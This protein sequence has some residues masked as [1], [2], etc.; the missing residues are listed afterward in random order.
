VIKYLT[1]V[2]KCVRMVIL[3]ILLVF[4]LTILITNEVIM[5]K[6][7]KKEY[8]IIHKLAKFICAIINTILFMLVLDID[9]PILFFIINMTYFFGTNTIAYILEAVTHKK[10]KHDIL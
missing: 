9:H 3:S 5:T 2:Y 4:S 7:D 10:H 8:F 6:K 1:K